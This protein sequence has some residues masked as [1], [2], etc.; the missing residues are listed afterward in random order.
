MMSSLVEYGLAIAAT[1]VMALIIWGPTVFV[2]FRRRQR[3]EQLTTAYLGIVLFAEFAVL[4]TVAAIADFAG[5]QDAGG[6]L[7]A[8]A[9][10]IGA[11]GPQALRFSKSRR[12]G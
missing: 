11:L 2:F 4:L 7:L 9:L 8:I 1:M 12:G 10:V 5:L 3:D 6:Y